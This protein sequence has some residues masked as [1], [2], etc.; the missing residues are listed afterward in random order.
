MQ[1][2]IR[3]KTDVL[4]MLEDEKARENAKSYNEVIKKLIEQKKISMFGADKEL[5]KW[6]ECEDRV[7]FRE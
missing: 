5:K 7:R 3:I 2:M 6:D 4:R 1:T